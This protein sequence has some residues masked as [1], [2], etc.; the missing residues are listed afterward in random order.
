[1][2]EIS[3]D[4]C[5]QKAYPAD[6]VGQ[7]EQRGRHFEAECAGGD[8]VDDKIEFGRLRDRKV[9]RLLALEN[10]AGI[11]ADISCMLSTLVP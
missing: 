2:S 9:G 4:I 7:R 3:S 5:A 8:Q 11:D 6:L 1:M 10:T